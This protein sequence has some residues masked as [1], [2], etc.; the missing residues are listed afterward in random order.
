MKKIVWVVILILCLVAC[1]GK[2]ENVQSLSPDEVSEYVEKSQSIIEDFYDEDFSKIR[3]EM[4]DEMK[5]VLKD[6]DLKNALVTIKGKGDFLEFDKADAVRYYDEKTDA[7]YIITQQQV[8]H[9][10]GKVIFTLNYDE[11]GKLAGFFFK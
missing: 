5:K 3:E 1:S 7:N 9:E 2:D 6:E 8:N 10:E 11:A 4:N